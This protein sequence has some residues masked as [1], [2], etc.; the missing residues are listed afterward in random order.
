MESMCLRT[1]HILEKINELLDNQSL[2]KCME[3][4]RIICSNIE[5]Q[6]HGKFLTTRLI[7][8]YIKNPLDFETDW[9]TIIQKLWMNRVS[10]FGIM[11]ND[12]YQAFPSRFQEKWAPMHW[13]N[14]IPIIGMDYYLSVLS[15]LYCW[16]F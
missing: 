8:I 14:N 4:S 12:F 13:G 11:V 7:Q 5:N 15:Y 9:K 10:E 2:V 3:A 1:P 6:K 16:Y